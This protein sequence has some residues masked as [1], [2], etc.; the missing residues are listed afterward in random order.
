M[1]YVGGDAN[2]GSKTIAINLPNDPEVQLRLGARRLQLKNAMQ[3]KFDRI[4]LPIVGVLMTEDQRD[5]VTFDAFF[6]NTMFHEVAHGLGIKN[7]I[8]GL[9]PVRQ[10][11][12]DQASGLEEGKADVLGLYMIA[13]LQDMGEL[14]EGHDLHENLTTFV[15]STFR[16]IRFGASSAHGRANVAR[17]NFFQEMGAFIREET[18]GTYRVDFEK[19]LEA[20]NSLSEKIL[21]FQGNGD[22]DGVVAFMEKYGSDSPPTPG[23]SGPPRRGR[24]SGGYRLRTGFGRPGTRGMRLDHQGSGYGVEMRPG[25]AGR[26]S[27]ARGAWLLVL[28][29]TSVGCGEGGEES[30]GRGPWDHLFSPGPGEFLQVSSYDTTGGNRDR[31]E[32]AP[33]DS[34][35]LLDLEGSGV[36]RRLWI[37]VASQ[38][39][40]YLRRIALRMYWDGEETPSVDVPLGDFFGNGFEKIHYTALPMG[41]SSGGF[42]CYL[43]MP[44]AR[45]A[46]IVAENGTGQAV[47]AF[48]FNA[49]VERGG[50]LSFPL[51][52]FHAQW[53][54]DPRTTSPRPHT[55]LEARGE[56]QLVGV[57]LNA[58]GYDDS[59]GYLE[60]DES[61]WIDGEFRGQGTGTEDY[62]NGGWYFQDGPFAA[63]FHGVVLMDPERGRVA[64]YRWHLP[65][66]VRFRDSIR[67][68][69]EHGH[70]NEAV[71]DL[72]SVAYWYQTE[73]HRPFPPLPQP[74]DRRLLAVRVPPDA[75]W[76]DSLVVEGDD[77]SGWTVLLPV[78]HPDRYQVWTY[79]AGPDGRSIAPVLKVPSVSVYDTLL[80]VALPPG[81]PLPVA[82]RAVARSRWAVEWLVVGPFPN[83]QRVGTEYS[84]ALD[85]VFPPEEDPSP[86]RS[87]PIQG[88]RMTGWVGATGDSTGYVRLNPHFVPNDWVAAYAQ[89]SLFSPTARPG[90][91]LLGADDAH[92]LWMNGELVSSRQGRNISVADDLSV[93]VELRA[94]WNRVLMKVAD[95]DGGWAFHLRAADPTGELRWAPTA[96]TH[97]PDTRGTIGEER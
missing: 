40:H 48:Y 3:A 88:G 63:P 73:P 38:D 59:F 23:R 20:M 6:E 49:S 41:V 89:A 32:I 18:T 62:F 50:H 86:G 30:V 54:R 14:S 95:L 27:R 29:F 61:F 8:N 11:M 12:K 4:L 34:A 97:D 25:G 68:E 94:G 70:A 77:D 79:P 81:D 96:P 55:L 45:S 19:T 57:S 10:A 64:A 53:T 85:S 9:G 46:R 36:I 80:A 5:L 31:F 84:P 39:P 17:F 76:V 35:V 24:D 58:E 16:S 42:Y 51:A 37:T 60:G 93:P 47:D 78:L 56:G 43:P 33:G 69:L 72:A 44:F 91:L 67:V 13:A 2:A 87:Y 74:D 66:P 83:P 65:D 7:T 15:S 75:R 92:E 28:L 52:T 71:A 22:Y 26:L 90:L 1:V 82:V 21:T